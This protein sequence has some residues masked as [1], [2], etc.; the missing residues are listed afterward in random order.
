MI[1][2]PKCKGGLPHDYQTDTAKDSTVLDFSNVLYERC[3]L[4]G[5]RKRWIKDQRTGRMRHEKEYAEA[6]IRDFAQP[7]G[8]T[9]QVYEMLYGNPNKRDLTT[10][11]TNANR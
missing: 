2:F 8:R 11:G 1:Y 7:Y 6:H 3:V 4:C 9:G 10:K 5:D